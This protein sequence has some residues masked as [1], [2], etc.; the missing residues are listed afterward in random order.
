[1]AIAVEFL[2]DG[3]IGG[4]IGVGSAEDDAAAKDESLWCRPGPD[5]RFELPAN[6]G[7]QIDLG[8]EGKWH[9]SL[10]ANRE[11]LL[12]QRDYGD[13]TRDRPAARPL[14]ANWR[15]IYETVI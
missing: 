8:A 9:G 13:S 1:M 2:R 3:V 12:H 14:L 15:R 4:L 5:E 10:R 6:L 11:S 7:G